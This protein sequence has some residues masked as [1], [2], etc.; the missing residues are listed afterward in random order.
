MLGV[1]LLD[2]RRRWEGEKEENS[3]AVTNAVTDESVN[4]GFGIS[5]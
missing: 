1:C 2:K 5:N 3:R 4:V